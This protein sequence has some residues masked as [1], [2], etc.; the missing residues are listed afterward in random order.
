MI[1]FILN[2]K[3]ISTNESE[4]ISLAD[5]IRYK[6]NLK[7]TKIGCREGDC[8]ACTVL[9]GE[10][11]HEKIEYKSITSCITPLKFAHAKHIVTVE[12]INKTELNTIQKHFHEH[13]ATQCGF[14]TPGF[15]MSL[16]GFSL[17]TKNADYSD[18]IKA[19]AGNICRCTGYKSIEKAIFDISEA[20]KLKPETDEINWLIENNFLPEYFSKI[21]EMLKEIKPLENIEGKITGGGTDLYVQNADGMSDKQ[22]RFIN[23]DNEK[24]KIETDKVIVHSSTTVS[25]II[26][27]KELKNIF[28]KFEKQLLLISSQQIRNTATI[29]GNFVNASPIGDLSIIFLALNSKIKINSNNNSL[30]QIFLKDFFKGYKTL[31][32]NENEFI[33]SLEFKIPKNNFKFNFEKVSKRKYLDIASVNTAIFISLKENIISEIHISGGGIAPI[34]MYFAKTSEYLKGKEINSETIKSAS[35]ILLSEISPISDVRGTSDYKKLL[36]KQ[37]FY[38]HFIELFSIKI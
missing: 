31:D 13:S 36:L 11:V 38:A 14:C 5:F 23:S 32:L 21:P 9:S 1:E 15:V 22:I 19:V 8:G 35:E 12:G 33:E 30:R 10:F 6:Q 37:L 17:N 25:E 34:P 29:A 18:G 27:S 28:P 20:L 26:Q 16:A 3:K 2:N 4:G 24:I 7:G